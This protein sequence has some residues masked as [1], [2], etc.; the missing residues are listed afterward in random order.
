MTPHKVATWADVPDR[1]PVGVLVSTVDLVIVRWDDA[2]SVLYGRCV[3]RGALLADGHVSGDNLICGVHGW[4][5]RVDTGISEYNNAERLDQFTSWV[6]NGDLF[7][8]LDE[9]EAWEADNP[10]PFDRNA[11]Q[12]AY[13]DPHGT[14]DEPH[15]ALIRKLA[16]EGCVEARASRPDGGDGGTTRQVAVVGRHP[17]RH[18]AAGP[19]A[20]TGRGRGVVGRRHR[21]QRSPSVVA[22]HPA[23]RVGI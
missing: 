1:E 8:D 15:V 10:Q 2:H 3:H 21:P 17:V 23:V 9:I 13:Q 16:G 19:S 22:R 12:G 6:E 5:Y 20:A 18:R 14:P 11:Y 7:V 4:D